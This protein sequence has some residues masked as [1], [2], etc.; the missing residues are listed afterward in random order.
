MH[1][2]AVLWAGHQV[3]HSSD[4]YNFSTAYGFCFRWQHRNPPS[5]SPPSMRQSWWQ[6]IT[7]I[8]IFAVAPFFPTPMIA[9]CS[10]L[11]T[12]YQVRCYWTSVESFFLLI[13][14]LL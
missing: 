11:N 8:T 12:L 13:A 7:H 6:A 2:N 3:H 4:H 10:I 5:L 1:T 9:Y 14:G